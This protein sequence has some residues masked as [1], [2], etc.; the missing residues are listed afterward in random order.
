M[1]LRE[2]RNGWEFDRVFRGSSV[3]ISMV[4]FFVLEG[5]FQFLMYIIPI[6]LFH[7]SFSLFAKCETLSMSYAKNR[8]HDTTIY[9]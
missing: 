9:V 1:A 7:V 3:V 8:N 2:Q 5:P 4:D 6:T